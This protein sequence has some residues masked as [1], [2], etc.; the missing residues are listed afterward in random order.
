MNTCLG[1]VNDI[2][3]N[4][5]LDEKSEAVLKIISDD[6]PYLTFGYERFNKFGFFRCPCKEEDHL[7]PTNFF[8]NNKEIIYQAALAEMDH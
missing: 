6:K 3:F 4:I 2:S 5:Q 1:T 8:N 7:N